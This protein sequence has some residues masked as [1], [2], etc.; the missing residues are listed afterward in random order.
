MGVNTSPFCLPH[1]L[2]EKVRGLSYN[3]NDRYWRGCIIVLCLVAISYALGCISLGICIYFTVV[4]IG[5][6]KKKISMTKGFLETTKHERS[7]YIGRPAKH[8]PHYV[9]AVY[10]Y[11]VNDKQFRI[12]WQAPGTPQNMPKTVKVFY[13]IKHP[14]FAYIEKGPFL[15][16][17]V[18]IVTGALS[19]I[20]LLLA[21]M[22]LF[23]IIH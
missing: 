12:T 6:T 1:L 10:A 11:R 21:T 20:I 5:F 19:I 3:T 13:Q 8:Y 17:F 14:Q 2:L 16:P 15:Q 9:Y 23:R 7:V 4:S 18:A 22:L